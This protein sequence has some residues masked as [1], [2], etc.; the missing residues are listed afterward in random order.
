MRKLVTIHSFKGQYTV[1]LYQTGFN[2]F[3]VQYGLEVRDG[4][5]YGQ[6]AAAF[7][8]GVMHAAACEGH[9]DNRSR[10]EA[11]KAGDTRPYFEA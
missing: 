7:G 8:E 3:E 9:L 1:Y 10:V 6:A 11:A 5:D 4:L 2:Q